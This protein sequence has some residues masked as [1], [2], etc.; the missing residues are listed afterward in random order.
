MCFGYSL[1]VVVAASV[2]VALPMGSSGTVRPVQPMAQP[3]QQ[4]GQ[5]AGQQPTEENQTPVQMTKEPGLFVHPVRGFSM[6]IPAGVAVSHRGQEMHVAIRSPKGYVLS[7][8]TG[9]ANGLIPLP[10]MLG[11][12]ESRYLGERG[13]WERK[14]SGGTLAVAGMPAIEGIY[15]GH[16]TRTRVI[17]VRGNKTDFVFTFTAPNDLYEEHKPVF[18]WVLTNFTPGDGERANQPAAA[19]A[20]NDPAKTPVAAPVRAADAVATM[21]TGRPEPAQ[22]APPQPNMSRFVE[23][24]YGFTMDYPKEWRVEKPTAYMATFSGPEGSAASHAVITVQNVNPAGAETGEQAATMA[25]A[26]LLKA[27]ERST[28]SMAVLGE[29][30]LEESP[31]SQFIARY[32]YL[33]TAYRKW[34]VIVPRPQGTIAHIWSFTAPEASFESFQPVAESMLR[35]W[36]L[37]Q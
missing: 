2:L 37:T 23:P 20:P 35:S 29:G 10:G 36:T 27:L 13:P 21:A 26:D 32:E 3:A 28:Q 24:G 16:R 1:K 30:K 15:Q 7:L 14:L 31:G 4:S 34:A 5:P 25:S 18:E 9:D 11:R 6:P 33:G 12:L 17:I 19:M 22:S 8:Q